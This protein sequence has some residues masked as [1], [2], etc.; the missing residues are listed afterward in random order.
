VGE[1]NVELARRA[2]EAVLR[3][4]IDLVAYLS[5]SGGLSLTR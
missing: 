1:T 2:F 5:G 4:D 3:G